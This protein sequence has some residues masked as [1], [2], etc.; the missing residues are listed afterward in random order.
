MSVVIDEVIAEPAPAGPAAKPSQ[1]KGAGPSKPLDI[2]W[3]NFE[4]QRS[5]HRNERLWA[6]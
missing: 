4:R 5:R 6:D 1:A 3:L 2:D